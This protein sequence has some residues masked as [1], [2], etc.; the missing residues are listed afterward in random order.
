M[1]FN[2]LFQ[3]KHVT[4]MITLYFKREIVSNYTSFIPSVGYEK[5]LNADSLFKEGA[6][7][8]NDPFVLNLLSH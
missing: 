6:S 3:K 8:K 2:I 4:E 1:N 5:G 7:V